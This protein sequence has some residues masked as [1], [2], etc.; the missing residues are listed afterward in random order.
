MTPTCSANWRFSSPAPWTTIS[1][2]IGWIDSTPWTQK[3]SKNFSIRCSEPT[4][5]PPLTKCGRPFHLSLRR[6]SITNAKP[7]TSKRWLPG[8]ISRNSCSPTERRL[9]NGFV[10]IPRF[11]GRLVTS[12]KICP[13]RRSGPDPSSLCESALQSVRDLHGLAFITSARTID[14]R[15]QLLQSLIF[16]LPRALLRRYR[17][18]ESRSSRKGVSL[19]TPRGQQLAMNSL[20][21][22][23]WKK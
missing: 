14:L 10:S 9:S 15:G 5:D 12:L 19:L 7:P 3:N 22:R 20:E 13:N 17:R 1:A 8:N 4:I 11:S 6:C 16:T 23:K 18:S 21:E 2:P